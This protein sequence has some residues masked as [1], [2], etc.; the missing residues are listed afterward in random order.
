MPDNYVV[1]DTSLT[2]A[3]A[4]IEEGGSMASWTDAWQGAGRP[5]FFYF[6]PGLTLVQHLTGS[7]LSHQYSTLASRTA[8]IV[9]SMAAAWTG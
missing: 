9:E 7:D 2:G 1:V 4:S 8:P 5:T 3:T 6:D